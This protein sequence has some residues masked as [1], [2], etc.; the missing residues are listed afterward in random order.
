M[1]M[2]LLMKK[3]VEDEETTA[4]HASTSWESWEKVV[5]LFVGS[6]EQPLLLLLPLPLSLWK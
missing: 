3:N 1:R 6:N 4:A 5:E 2:I